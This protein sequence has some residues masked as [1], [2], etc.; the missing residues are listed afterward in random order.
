MRRARRWFQPERATGASLRQQ[1]HHED[2]GDD[3]RDDR[4]RA[5]GH[6]EVPP[7]SRRQDL[8]ELR[9]SGAIP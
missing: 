2:D 9:R 1:D 4:D 5:C 3:Q 7:W 6:G 8:G